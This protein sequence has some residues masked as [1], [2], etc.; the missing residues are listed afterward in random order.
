METFDLKELER[1]KCT[2]YGVC[3]FSRFINGHMVT[4]KR[5]ETVLITLNFIWCMKL[6]YPSDRFWLDNG[7]EFQIELMN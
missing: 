2:F 1:E 4:N 7:G 6:G 3:S 5:A